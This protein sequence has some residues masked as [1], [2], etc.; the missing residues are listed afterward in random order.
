MKIAK[1]TLRKRGHYDDLVISMIKPKLPEAI[2][3]NIIMK[4]YKERWMLI[5]QKQHQFKYV[6][7][8]L[9]GKKYIII[10]MSMTEFEV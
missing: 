6:K 10:K 8:G 4:Q 5:K 3:N 9:E 7:N 2:K 1:T